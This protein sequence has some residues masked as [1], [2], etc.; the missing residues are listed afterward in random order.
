MVCHNCF[1]PLE[2][3]NLTCSYCGTVNHPTIYVH[4]QHAKKRFYSTRKLLIV[5]SAL[6]GVL[7]IG[8][9][10]FM[11][12]NQINAA[13][14]LSNAKSSNAAFNYQ[15]A[16]K[17]LDTAKKYWALPKTKKDI[18][19]TYDT[20]KS[21]DAYSQKVTAADAALAASEFDKALA[22]LADAPKDFPQSSDVDKKRLA[23]QTKIEDAAKKA[24]ADAEA[25]KVAAAEKAKAE[26]AAKKPTVKKSTVPASVGKRY[27][28]TGAKTQ[29]SSATTIVGVEAALSTF[30]A[31]YGV[32]AKTTNM[33]Q[34]VYGPTTTWDYLT[35]SDLA[36]LK[37]I[38]TAFIDEWAKY[39]VD[40]V[41][42]TGLQSVNFVKY[43]TVSG[44]QRTAMPGMSA[45][46]RM[47]YGTGANGAIVH[48]EFAHYFESIFFNTL[49]WNVDTWKA[50]NPP[51]FVYGNGGATAYGAAPKY[52]TYEHPISSFVTEYGTYG[53][54]ED[55]AELHSYLMTASYYS[56]LKTWLTTDASL[57]G[58]VTL[59]KNMLQAHSATMSGTY[60]DEI[61]N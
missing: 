3:M 14:Y 32:V 45:D 44:Q 47:W 56:R 41:K 19:S 39:P 2:G 55:R 8:S 60:F 1:N 38:A 30:L 16:V 51:G 11:S 21:W 48:H 53:I 31:Q 36:P 15:D 10:S 23:I 6:I 25:A 35:E 24:A 50:Y 28:D 33:P 59:Y 46:K 18:Q 42:S 37:N 34:S 20:T 12:F 17:Q 26:A 40:F 49:Q 52:A 29:V 43:V 22:L 61:N 27:A 7:V 58:K 13:K 57:Q 5:A 54:E 9:V 4:S